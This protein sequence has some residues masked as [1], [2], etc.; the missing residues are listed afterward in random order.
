M[1][2]V[3]TVFLYNHDEATEDAAVASPTEPRP[4]GNDVIAGGTQDDEIWGQLGDDIIQGDGK[5]EMLA[6]PAEFKEF[7]PAQDEIPNFGIR[8]EVVL[9]TLVSGIDTIFQFSAFEDEG[10]GDDYIEGNGGN[11]RIYGGLGQDDLI[12]GSSILFGLDGLVTNR[13][14]GADMIYGGAGNPVQLSRNASFTGPDNDISGDASVAVPTDERHARDADV[15]LGDNGE[16]YR[17]VMENPE[18]HEIEG[19][20]FFNYDY[21]A[22]TANGFVDDGFNGETIMIIPRA[23]DLNDYGYSYEDSD[24]DPYTREVLTFTDQVRGEGDLIYGESGDDIIHGM[25]GNDSIFG[26]S[27]HDDIYGEIGTDFLLGGTGIDGILGDDGLILTRRNRRAA[28][29]NCPTR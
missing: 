23:V 5:I 20:E 28:L 6:K 25:T 13:P 27:E 2:L 24:A 11:D 1:T 19:Y 10:D 12:G 18:T 9:D 8:D 29:W 14:D 4:F 22:T 7:N 26:N 21:D 16:I 15:I 3:R 17:I